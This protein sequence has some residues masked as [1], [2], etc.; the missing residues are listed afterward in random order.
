[1]KI[2]YSTLKR[3]IPNIKSPEDLA[4]D[5]IMHTAEVE[6]IIYEGK[7]FDNMV[8][9]EITEINK[10]P[11]ADK[12]SVCKVNIWEE[13]TQI[14]CGWTNLELGQK[15]AVAKI[16]ATVSWH[17]EETITMKKT[18]IR[19]VESNWMICASE[20]IWLD[21]EFPAKSHTEILDLSH[22]NSKAWTPLAQALN[23]NEVILEIDNKAINHRPDLF[24]HIWVIRELFAI[25]WEKF[26]YEYEDKNFSNLSDLWIKNEIPDVVKRYIGLKISGVENIESPDYIKEVLQASG[27]NSKWL[28]VD[29]SNYSLYMYGQPTHIFDA[30][31]ISGNIVVRYAKDWERFTALDDKEYELT[32]KDIVIAD[33]EKILA[34]WGIIWG[35]SSAVSDTTKNIIIEGANFDQAILRMTGKRLGIRTDSLNIFEKDILP[36]SAKWWVSLIVSELEKYFPNLKLEAYSDIFPKK[37]KQ[38]EIDFDLDFVNRLI[39]KE[40][41]LDTAKK[42]LT[43]LWIEIKNNKLIIP[44]WRKELNYK[45][46]IAEEIARIDGYDKVE[47]KIPE[48][49]LWAI[50]QDNIYN[51]KRIARNFF[52]NKGFYDMYTY[53]FVNKDLMEKSNSSI[54]S[55]V[56]LKNSLSEEA[57]HMKNSLIQNLL[58]SLEK[59]IRDK[60]DL[61]LFEIE[62]VFEKTKDNNIKENYHLAWIITSNKDI[63]Y[64]DI[65]NIVKDFLKT[66]WI[67][68]FF[69]EKAKNTPW[70][71]H[72]GRTAELIVRWQSVWL[73]GEIHPKIAKNFDV[74]SRLGFFEIDL[75][76]LSSM[77]FSIPKAKEISNFQDSNFDISFEISPK[78]KGSKL[79]TTIEKTA[80]KLIQKVE[81]IDIYKNKEKLWENTAVTFKVYIWKMD[82]EVTDKEKNEL[83]KEIIAKAEKL[84]AK[85]R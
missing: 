69:F 13:E 65:Q 8:I 16:G 24:S 29:L 27:A 37:Q 77:A 74:K 1:M 81:L 47:A 43:N 56:E 26:D 75:D 84:W 22:L 44:A 35:K 34:L 46:D 61:K 41:S 36:V 58:L 25:T 71:T 72:N 33:D 55:L 39:W 62:K 9:W 57:T 6:E 64:Y 83:I 5:L 66:I 68:K 73:I 17:G 48:I 2:S 78:I 4:Q 31:K 32:S 42:I 3:Y 63:V 45:A 80:P 85:H 11:D 49:Q 76:K 12:L 14:V 30:D 50:M 10:H 19:W 53:S 7:N 20:E 60:K 21:K 15:V 52:V 67:D 28:L 38:V 54:E 59:N 70:F 79:K 51:I 82:S 40:Y 23:K 18:K